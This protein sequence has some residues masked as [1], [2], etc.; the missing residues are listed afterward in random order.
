M[1]KCRAMDPEGSTCV[2]KYKNG[3]KNSVVTTQISM[4]YGLRYDWFC[5]AHSMLKKKICVCERERE[6]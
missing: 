4:N 1:M 6:R 3:L 5:T 2:S